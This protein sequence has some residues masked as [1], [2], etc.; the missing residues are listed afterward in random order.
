M[1][2]LLVEHLYLSLP[3]LSP[4]ARAN[5]LRDVKGLLGAIMHFLEKVAE[6]A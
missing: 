5:G 6:A 1:K 4:I 2:L 3:S